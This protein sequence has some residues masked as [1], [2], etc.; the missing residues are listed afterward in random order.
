MPGLHIVDGSGLAERDRIAP[1]TMVRLLAVADHLPISH[2]YVSAFPRAGIEGTVRHHELGPALG[3]VHAKS[4]HIDGVNALVGYVDTHRH[5]RL[6]FAFLVNAPYADD[7]TS[8]QVGID[9]ALD[10]LVSL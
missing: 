4:G 7:A 10:E 8:I 3:R 6:A 2:A 9:R 1:I 5:G